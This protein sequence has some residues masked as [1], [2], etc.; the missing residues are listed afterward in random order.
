MAAVKV[1]PGTM[2]MMALMITASIFILKNTSRCISSA[3][4]ARAKE[5]AAF[6]QKS[7]NLRREA[8]VTAR[9]RTSPTTPA[10]TQSSQFP[11]NNT[12]KKVDVMI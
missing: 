2:G 7:L 4:T 10:A 8:P 11:P 1:T 5:P 6:W 3:V 9:A 12:A